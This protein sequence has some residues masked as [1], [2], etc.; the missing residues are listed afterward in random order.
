VAADGRGAAAEVELR[1]ATR[2][3][4]LWEQL[5]PGARQGQAAHAVLAL[6]AVAAGDDVAVCALYADGA[7][8]LWSAAR[9][10]VLA[11][12]QLPRAAGPGTAAGAVVG[13]W[14]RRLRIVVILPAW[15]E[16][17]G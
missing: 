15:R 1:E 11:A 17:R 10:A 8:R 3:Q 14:R 7:L 4:R 13:A 6:D 2:V 5:L 16:P 9:A 12:A